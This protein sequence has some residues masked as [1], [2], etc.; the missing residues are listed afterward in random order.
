MQ[1]STGQTITLL[2]GDITK[3]KV[4][5][6][7]NAANSKLEHGGGVAGAIRAKAGPTF[8]AESQQFVALH[9]PVP[10]GGAVTTSGGRLPSPKVIHAVGPI[11]GQDP[12]PEALLKKAVE[13]T[14]FEAASLS[15]WFLSLDTTNN[16]NHDYYYYYFKISNRGH[17]NLH[18]SSLMWHLRVSCQLCRRSD[19][20]H[21]P[22]FPEP[23]LS[24]FFENRYHRRSHFQA[25]QG[26]FPG[27]CRQSRKYCSP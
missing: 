15:T 1:T 16:D 14:L 9:G 5:A 27:G 17:S 2:K 20:S 12:N 24:A 25:V 26:G 8:I 23:E 13:S 3:E 19:S 10:V 7:V 18:A 22:Q 11:W 4:D 6:I 21:S